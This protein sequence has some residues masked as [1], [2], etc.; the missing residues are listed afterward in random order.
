MNPNTPTPRRCGLVGQ[1]A[2][3]D[4]QG[5]GLGVHLHLPPAQTLPPY[6]DAVG[7]VVNGEKNFM[8][9]FYC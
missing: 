7:R 8:C 3:L 4:L 6:H 5:P 2:A 9:L 1:D